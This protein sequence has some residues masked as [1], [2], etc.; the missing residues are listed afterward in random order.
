MMRV[1]TVY[2][3]KIA[4]KRVEKNSLFLQTKRRGTHLTAIEVL[5]YLATIS[6]PTPIDV[7]I[8]LVISLQKLPVFNG[9]IQSECFNILFEE[10]LNYNS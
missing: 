6:E 7:S 8:L 3:E 9:E 4:L 5:V 1:L 2:K 10:S